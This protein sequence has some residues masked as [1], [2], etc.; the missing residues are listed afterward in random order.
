MF[1]DS[2]LKMIGAAGGFVVML[3]AFLW[4]VRFVGRAIVDELKALRSDVKDHTTKDLEHHAEVKEAIVRLEGKID[5][6]LEERDRARIGAV[7]RGV[8]RRGGG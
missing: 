3:A 5:G 8:E 6:V 7:L 1:D 4:L 2:M